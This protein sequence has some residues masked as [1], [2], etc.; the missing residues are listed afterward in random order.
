M[1]AIVKQREIIERRALLDELRL[2]AERPGVET[3]QPFTERLKEAYQAGYEEIRRRFEEGSSG[4]VAVREHCFLMD[5]LVRVL[6]DFVADHVYP[7]ANTTSG[8]HLG[9]VAVGGYGRGELAPHSD[10]DL[11]FLLPYKPTPHTEQVVE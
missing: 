7:L 2:L 10:V 1:H 3:R 11:L 9:V 6:H 4:T 8:E 5:Q